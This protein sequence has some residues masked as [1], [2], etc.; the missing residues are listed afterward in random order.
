MYKCTKCEATRPTLSGKCPCCGEWNCM[1]EVEAKKKTYTIPKVSKKAKEQKVSSESETRALEAWFEYHQ[2]KAKEKPICENC[3]KNIEY[4]LNSDE[5][6]IWKSSHAH[7]FPKKTFH[8]VKTNLNNHL[9]L[10]KL[11]H[12]QFDS[13]WL[14]AQKMKVW[15]IAKA[16]AQK[17]LLS[18][19]ESITKIEEIGI[20]D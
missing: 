16:R 5:G 1:V 14:N 10:C 7:I 13:S 6:W 2:L 4:Q 3:G 17:L 19:T 12:G 20:F 11:C 15:P 9:L 8:S 18:I